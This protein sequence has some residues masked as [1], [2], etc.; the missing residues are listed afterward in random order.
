MN[1][2]IPQ[3][4]RVVNFTDETL[5]Q[6]PI[7]TNI[8]DKPKGSSKGLLF[9]ITSFVAGVIGYIFY[10]PLIYLLITETQLYFLQDWNLIPYIG[11]IAIGVSIIGIVVLVRNTGKRYGYVR[12]FLPL[13]F[14]FQSIF[15]M[16]PTVPGIQNPLWPLYT[17]MSA[18]AVSIL[19]L[20]FSIVILYRNSKVIGIL[21]ALG[22]LGTTGWAILNNPQ[23]KIEMS[24][25][26]GFGSELDTHT[27]KGLQK[28]VTKAGTVSF[29]LGENVDYESWGNATSTLALVFTE[30]N[31]GSG[32]AFGGC[33]AGTS[34]IEIDEERDLNSFEGYKL[35]ER[36]ET[37]GENTYH[38]YD[39]RIEPS[40]SYYELPYENTVVQI[41]Y[42]PK[43]PC[44]AGKN[45]R[46]DLD[47]L[48]KTFK[49]DGPAKQSV[50]D[51]KA[52]S[53]I[54]PVTVEKKVMSP[55]LPKSNIT[56]K[57]EGT[58]ESGIY[59][60]LSYTPQID[61][62][63]VSDA[64]VDYWYDR[65]FVKNI[66]VSNYDC[67]NKYAE[68]IKSTNAYDRAKGIAEVNACLYVLVYMMP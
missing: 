63:Y 53:Y 12:T 48:L 40:I 44:I 13:T 28:I 17:I 5:H 7:S 11:L 16:L 14:I 68:L 9:A 59:S 49:Y 36:E 46:P 34:F 41:V 2:D 60:D 6:E 21:L 65:M 4:P 54:P 42:R 64:Q 61:K 26:A 15:I 57:G 1:N 38:V 22:I 19:G 51:A 32:T 47:L 58:F 20:V 3:A 50:S 23:I 67:E 10:V 37:Y 45:F 31:K 33:G 62:A 66:S 27:Q 29:E 43:E 24:E 52:A 18:A 39:W 25:K 35:N 55:T 8:I 56:K 30:N